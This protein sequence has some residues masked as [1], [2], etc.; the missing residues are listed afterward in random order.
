MT[1][2]EIDQLEKTL[3]S[4]WSLC[5]KNKQELETHGD[6]TNVIRKDVGEYYC[7]RCQKKLFG[8]WSDSR[9][10]SHCGK[11]LRWDDSIKIQASEVRKNI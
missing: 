6:R 9:Y 5:N 1:K 3:Y 8:F 4:L 2:E 11:A 10:C 7:P